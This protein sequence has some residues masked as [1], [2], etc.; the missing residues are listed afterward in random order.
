MIVEFFTKEADILAQ[1]EQNTR[2]K[3]DLDNKIKVLYRRL[4]SNELSPEI[5][6]TR[7]NAIK[8]KQ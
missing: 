6:I 5:I 3:Q 2:K 8:G 4:I 1:I 7:K